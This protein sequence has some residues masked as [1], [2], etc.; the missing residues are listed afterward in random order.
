[1]LTLLLGW[2]GLVLL[3]VAV[4]TFG[5][6]IG[7]GG[8][9]I[10]V[11][12]LLLLYPDSS[13]TTIASISLAVVCLNAGSGTLAYARLGRVDYRN[14]TLFAIA[15]APGSVIGALVT[16][17]V[18]RG[19][20]DA[21]FGA[22]LIILSGYLLLRGRPVEG[23]VIPERVNTRLG[24]LLSFGVGFMSSFLGIGGGVIHVPLLIQVLGYPAHIATATSH[25]VLAISAAIGTATHILNG[26]FTTGVR[27]TIALGLGVLAGA[28]FG[29]A[30]S[31]RVRGTLIVRALALALLLI[32]LRL[33]A[34]PLL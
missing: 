5:T 1:M 4:G 27:R 26:D 33:L 20:F 24:I 10:L 16:S 13:P 3:G 2:I 14:G 30:L 29:A 25:Y 34:E 19:L 9:F 21:I 12:V 22:V 32:G 11:P 6:L 18:P 7:A 15:T 28:Q 23:H 17:L 8:G 31:Q